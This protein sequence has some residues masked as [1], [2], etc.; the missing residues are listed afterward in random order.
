M[1]RLIDLTGNKIGRWTVISRAENGSCKQVRWE[2]VCEC[3]TKKSVSSQL[4]I[5]GSS[6]SCGCVQKEMMKNRQTHG[7][8]H[9]NRTPEYTTWASMI[10]RCTNQ[11]NRNYH[12][13]GG[14][15]IKICSEWMDFTKFLADMGDR[16][17][18]YSLDRIDVNGDYCKENCKWSSQTEQMHNLRTNN[19]YGY[20][21]IQYD[22]KK[23][24][25]APKITVSNKTIHLGRFKTL[26]EAIEARKQ[27]EFKYWGKS[28]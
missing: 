27:A 21:G 13:Y 2:C 15:G 6:T 1:G 8:S 7:K 9:R 16:P 14:R 25:F 3:G 18:G 5:N 22:K 23:K 19:K 12:H 11:N 24:R 26:E 28:S 10:Q 4:L 17:D 20:P